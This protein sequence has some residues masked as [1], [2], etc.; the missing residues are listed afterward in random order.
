[1][2]LEWT[3]L[4]HGK[5]LSEWKG[6]RFEIEMGDKSGKLVVN[7]VC[8]STSKE[9]EALKDQANRVFALLRRTTND[10]GSVEYF[11]E[12]S[13]EVGTTVRLKSG[14][15]KMTVVQTEIYGVVT[16]G[17]FS[18]NNGNDEFKSIQIRIDA[19]DIIERVA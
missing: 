13:L 17:F 7:G 15:P 6:F 4:S 3:E 14:G 10:N 12:N 19:L 18:L 11:R 5:M 9:Q 2:I 16:A 8:I 1:M